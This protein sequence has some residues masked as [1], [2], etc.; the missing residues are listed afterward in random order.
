[1]TR[2]V[3]REVLHRGFGGLSAEV[4]GVALGLNGLHRVGVCVGIFNRNARSMSFG[5]SCHQLRPPFVD[6][7][8]CQ[9]EFR[10]VVSRLVHDIEVLKRVGCFRL[11]RSHF[12]RRKH[13]QR[14]QFARGD[15]A[16]IDRELI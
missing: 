16:A 4:I 11:S 7:L 14:R 15:L 10:M 6:Q 5:Q 3:H 8:L 1:M 12:D 2:P 9:T 13:T